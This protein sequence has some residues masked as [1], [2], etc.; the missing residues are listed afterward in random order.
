[1]TASR[2]ERQNVPRVLEKEIDRELKRELDGES[3]I[4]VQRKK[5][6][7]SQR[8]RMIQTELVREFQRVG[9]PVKEVEMIVIRS[10]CFE[11]QVYLLFSKKTKT[12]NP[13]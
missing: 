11:T 6:L 2:A 12:Q 7:E 4:E 9:E 10:I 13:E 1:M 3:K 5:E 8:Q